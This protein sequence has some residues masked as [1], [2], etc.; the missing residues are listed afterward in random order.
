MKDW[1][2]LVFT[3]AVLP[4]LYIVVVVWLFT[5]ATGIGAS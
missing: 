1:P 2:K 3:A 4:A 5:I